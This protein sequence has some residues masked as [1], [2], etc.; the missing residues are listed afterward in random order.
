MESLITKDLNSLI[1]ANKKYSVIYCDAPWSFKVYS[2]KGKKRSAERHYPTQT[3][4]AIK[5]VPVKKLAADDCVLMLWAVLPQIPEA[6]QVIRAWGFEYKTTAFT[7]VKTV[8]SGGLHWGLGYWT[9]ANCEICMLATKGS[10][11]RL[12][13]DVH[14]VVMEAVDRHSKKPYEVRRRIEKLV[15][16]PY[17]ELYGRRPFEGWTVWGNQIVKSIDTKHIQELK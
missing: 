8:K 13:K 3:L 1:K 9:R 14:Q 17:L 11:K 12:S 2:V 5:R 6:L 15:A 7:W 10:P 4:D 16:G